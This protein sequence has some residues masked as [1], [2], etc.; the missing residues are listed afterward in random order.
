MESR[1]KSH[2]LREISEC[3]DKK[4]DTEINCRIKKIGKII[5]VSVSFEEQQSFVDENGVRWV[6]D[7]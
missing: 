3:I 7:L 4:R 1:A 5:K 6:R 2:I